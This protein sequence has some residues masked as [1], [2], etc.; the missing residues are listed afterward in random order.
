MNL[1]TIHPM[2]LIFKSKLTV[3]PC[4]CQSAWFYWTLLDFEIEK[5]SLLAMPVLFFLRPSHSKPW[6]EMLSRFYST[7]YPFSLLISHVKTD[8]KHWDWQNHLCLSLTLLHQP[9]AGFKAQH[10]LFP[11]APD[12]GCASSRLFFSLSQKDERCWIECHFQ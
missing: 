4:A 7:D 9:T 1:P 10:F 11:V 6:N 2:V 12:Y 3:I 5:P 8:W